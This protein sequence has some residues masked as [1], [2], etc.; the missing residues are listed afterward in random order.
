[1]QEHKK[2][3]KTMK[4]N[5]FDV[6]FYKHPADFAFIFQWHTIYVEVREK[7]TIMYMD[8]YPLLQQTQVCITCISVSEL[9]FS[10]SSPKNKIKWI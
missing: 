8:C 3:E 5:E 10:Q 1:M 7:Q 2:K 4:S 6:L 9:F